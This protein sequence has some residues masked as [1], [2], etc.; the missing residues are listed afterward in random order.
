MAMEKLILRSVMYG[1]D[2]IPDTWFDKVPGGFYK[3]TQKADGKGDKGQKID[4]A[5]DGKKQRRYSLTGDDRR[6][7]RRDLYED[8]RRAND[9]RRHDRRERSSYDVSHDPDYTRNDR[10][11]ERGGER[12]RRRHSADGDRY[13][14]NEDH[15]RSSNAYYGDRKYRGTE[16]PRPPDPYFDDRQRP[17]TGDGSRGTAPGSSK[18]ST[19]TTTTTGLAGVAAA[20]AG[21]AYGP[22]R[23]GPRHAF[24]MPSSPNTH[25]TSASSGRPQSSSTASS[26]VPFA[27]IYGSPDTGTS[28]TFAPPQTSGT[29]PYPRVVPTASPQGYQQNPFAQEAPMAANAGPA[30]HAPQPKVPTSARA[31]AGYGNRPPYPESPRSSRSTD[32]YSPAYAN[33]DRRDSD[34]RRSRSERRPDRSGKE[35]RDYGTFEHTTNQTC[36]LTR[37]SR[38]TS[39]RRPPI[40]ATRTGQDAR[41]STRTSRNNRQR[42]KTRLGT[43]ARCTP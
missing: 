35:G 40:T 29:V 1:V 28:P 34:V 27:H 9:H 18:A 11:G 19:T 6:R 23:R 10:R 39:I 4:G 31:F 17:V 32:R 8:E 12:R 16:Q 7:T 37:S 21:A 43:R 30:M 13:G 14:D 24:T 20:E 38:Q 15:P 42:S 26:Y 2:K 5:S 3:S 33:H 25:A 36:I 22:P 41:T